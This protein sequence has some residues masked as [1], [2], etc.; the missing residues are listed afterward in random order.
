MRNISLFSEEGTYNPF[1]LRSC[2]GYFKIHQAVTIFGI[3]ASVGMVADF[4]G[5]YYTVGCVRAIEVVSF[6]AMTFK[7]GKFT[8][9]CF[10]YAF[11]FNMVVGPSLY[12]FGVDGVTEKLNISKAAERSC[13]NMKEKELEAHGY[14]SVEDCEHQMYDLIWWVMMIIVPLW[15]ILQLYFIIVVFT[16]WKNW[17]KKQSEGGCIP[18][19]NNERKPWSKHM[20]KP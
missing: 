5:G 19:D 8:R 7:D 10:F 12:L 14:D 18:D 6:F 3:V 9:M 2:L 11:V 15:I 13:E 4:V 20:D 16:H 17:K 1:R